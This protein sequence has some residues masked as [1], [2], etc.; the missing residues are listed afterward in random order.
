MG[1]RHRRAPAVQGADLLQRVRSP[2]AKARRRGGGRRRTSR[3]RLRCV[4][5]LATMRPPG[6]SAAQ[7]ASKTPSL[8]PATEEDRVGRGQAFERFRRS[9]GDDLEVGR[10]QRRRVTR[11]ARGALG[12]LLDA[13]GAQRGVAAAAIRSR[14]S[15]RRARCPTA[16]RRGAGASEDST[17]ART[18]RLVSWPSFSKRSSSSPA[19]ERDDAGVRAGRRP[20]ARSCSTDRRRRARSLCAIALRT[21]SPAPPMR[22]STVSRRAAEPARVSSAASFAGVVPSHDSARMRAPGCR[23]RTMPASARPCRL[24][25]LTSCSAQPRRAAASE[26]ADACGRQSELVGADE[27]G[28]LLADAEM[29]GVA[30]GEHDDR[31]PARGED[32]RERRLDGAR[33]G[34]PLPAYQIAGEREMA[35]AADDELGVHDEARCHGVQAVGAVLADAD[36]GQPPLQC[37]VMSAW[38]RISETLMRI[39]I[40]GGTTEASALA[41]RLGGR[42]ALAATLSLAGRTASRPSCRRS[43]RASAASAARRALRSGSMR[44]Q[45]RI[46]IVDAT[47]PFAARISANAVAAAQH[48][49]RCRSSRSCVRP[50]AQQAGDRWIVCRAMR[51]RPRRRSGREPARVFLTIGRQ[52]VAAFR[53]APQ[54]NYLVRVDR[55]RP[56][57]DALPP[58]PRSSCSADRS[59]SGRDGADARARHRYRRRQ[60]LRR[61]TRP[62]PKSRRRA[63]FGCPSS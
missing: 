14:S 40:L 51:R 39:L 31:A 58:R 27:R 16:A 1:D 21:R 52:E 5:A 63:R 15:R 43:R 37:G 23:W 25:R 29:K 19:A 61:R 13:D 6:F 38:A 53:A 49:R 7:A 45:H 62:T 22:S 32:A 60:E 18:S 55:C 44:Q 36:D 47:H 11:R 20:R 54:H 48:G 30:R 50:G 34:E 33:P 35:L 4:T 56:T 12:V 8:E 57:P 46:S 24:T 2:S 28:E 26:K 10:A 17:I 9:A 59:T 3:A 41:R 42:R